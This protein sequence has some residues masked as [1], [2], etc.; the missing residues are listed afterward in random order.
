MLKKKKNADF[1]VYHREILSIALLPVPWDILELEKP[2]S[3]VS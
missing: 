1:Q 2:L 3:S